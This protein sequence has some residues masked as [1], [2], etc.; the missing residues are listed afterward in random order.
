M[1][2]MLELPESG[3]HSPSTIPFVPRDSEPIRSDLLGPEHLEAHAR[4]LARV[5]PRAVVGS[6]RP[7]HGRLRDNARALLHDHRLITEAVRGGAKFGTDAEWLLDNFHIVADALAEVRVDLPRGYY[8]LLPKMTGGPHAGFPRV[9]MLAVELVAHTDSSLNSAHLASFIQA[10]QSVTPLTIGELWA[11]PIMLRV[12][13]LENLRCLADQIVR[14]HADRQAAASWAMEFIP[15]EA[16]PAAAPAC[17]VPGAVRPPHTD[18]S[19]EFHL[20]L[21]E[22]INAREADHAPWLHW[23]EAALT[24][25]GTTSVELMRRGQQ[26]QAVNQVSIGN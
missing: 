8:K 16:P 22:L 5:A 2:A 7:L 12:V 4:C 24:S 20:H 11:V 6:G 9:Y 3:S 13:L 1:T 10:Y 25:R 26:R 23:L 17:T 14:A 15:P 21:L 18:C 19:D